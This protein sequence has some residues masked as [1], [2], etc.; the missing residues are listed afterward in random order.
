MSSANGVAQG[1]IAHVRVSECSAAPQAGAAT[2]MVFMPA[3]PLEAPASA[4]RRLL[5]GTR[6]GTVL[7]IGDS[8]DAA[9]S[10]ALALDV[11]GDEVRTACDGASG[12]AAA[13]SFMSHLVRLQHALPA[14]V[15][16]LPIICFRGY[17]SIVCGKS[18]TECQYSIYKKF[19][20]KI[21]CY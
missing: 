13:Q 14:L 16:F 10:L 15:F 20:L 3:V 21:K 1:Q 9:E 8:A 7:V 12:V 2:T 4:N 18:N 6:E 5:A 11:L 19:H 17:T